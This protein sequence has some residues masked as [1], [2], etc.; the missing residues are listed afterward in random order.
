[1]TGAPAQVHDALVADQDLDGGGAVF[2]HQRGALEGALPAPDDGHP[3]TGEDAQVAVVG[4]VRD[5]LGGKLLVARGSVREGRDPARDHH[6]ARRQL[7]AVGER[8][9][10]APGAA[11]SSETIRSS[12]SGT[13]SRVTHMP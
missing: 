7:F 10:K 1:M 6:R 2:D 4:A 3:A 13:A 12:T 11:V 9:A 5:A 8:E